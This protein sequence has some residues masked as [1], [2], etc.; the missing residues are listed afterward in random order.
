MIPI[1]IL[2]RPGIT[3]V[4]YH[5]S[6]PFVMLAAVVRTG[7]L[8]ATLDLGLQPSEPTGPPLGALFESP[9]A[10]R[11][12]LVAGSATHASL[13]VRREDVVLDCSP[14]CDYLAP[15]WREGSGSSPS[16]CSTR[17]VDYRASHPP[18]IAIVCP[19]T[20]EEAGEAR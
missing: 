8:R 1:S 7:A 17:S 6:R 9:H 12:A 3:V 16:V 2:I 20:Y 15:L 11:I 5:F 13:Y 18:S 14:L 10:G 19:V 4:Y